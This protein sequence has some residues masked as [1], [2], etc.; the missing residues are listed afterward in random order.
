M[1]LTKTLL[2]QMIREA[3]DDDPQQWLSPD[4]KEDDTD[5]IDHLDYLDQDPSR[6]VEPLRDWLN[7]ILIGRVTV[8]LRDAAKDIA[9]EVY[10]D[11]EYKRDLF[12]AVGID[13]EKISWI[14][15]D[16]LPSCLPPTTNGTLILSALLLGLP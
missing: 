14:F 7:D 15:F 16:L 13:I 4:A 1:K 9:E 2:E 12:D 11:E 5:D 3:V 6:R 8:A 10:F